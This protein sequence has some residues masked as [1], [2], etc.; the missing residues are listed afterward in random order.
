MGR[1]CWRFMVVMGMAVA[2]CGGSDSLSPREACDQLSAS[3]C[4][5]FYACYTTAELS[6]SGFPATESA[7]VTMLQSDA[8]CA[9]VTAANTCSANETFHGDQANTCVDQISGLECSRIRDSNFDLDTAAPAC[10]K[11]CAMN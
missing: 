5:R 4:E 7:C 6:S 3:L 11:T 10:G 9:Q 2:G 1:M 8:G